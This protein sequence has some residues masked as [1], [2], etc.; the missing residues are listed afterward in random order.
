MMLL[1]WTAAAI[2]YCAIEAYVAIRFM[3]RANALLVLWPKICSDSKSSTAQT[4]ISKSKFCQFVSR[5][6]FLFRIEFVANDVQRHPFIHAAGKVCHFG[7]GMLALVFDYR[8]G[9]V[10]KGRERNKKKQKKIATH[11]SLHLLS[12]EVSIA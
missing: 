5:S 3:S 2:L 12:D 9:W 11:G 6:L 1:I 4:Y 8:S 10:G 7:I